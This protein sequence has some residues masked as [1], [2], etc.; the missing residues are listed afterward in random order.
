MAPVDCLTNEMLIPS[1][2]AFA[3][4]NPLQVSTIEVLKTIELMFRPFCEKVP[5]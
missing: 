3:R 5:Q 2:D 4:A 1:E